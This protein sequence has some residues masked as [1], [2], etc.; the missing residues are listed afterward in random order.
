MAV[1]RFLL[2][3]IAMLLSFGAGAL[4]YVLSQSEL[5]HI[6]RVPLLGEMG[7]ETVYYSLFAAFL[8]ACLLLLPLGSLAGRRE[9]PGRAPRP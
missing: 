4:A 2:G 8:V 5:G 3:I 1:I 6:V 9:R 7:L